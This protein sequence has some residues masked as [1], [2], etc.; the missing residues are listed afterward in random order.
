MIEIL[1]ALTLAQADDT[2]L[3]R[4]GRVLTLAGTDLERGSVLV[5]GGKI[6]RVAAEIEAPPGARVIEAAGKLVMPGLVDGGTA[7]GFAGSAW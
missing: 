3:I 7:A 5:R 2:V 1:L 6:L 4:G